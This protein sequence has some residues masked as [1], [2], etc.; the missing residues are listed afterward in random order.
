MRSHH[1]SVRFLIVHTDYP[2]FLDS[3]YGSEPGLADADYATQLDRRYRSRFGV[4]DFYSYNLGELGHQAYDVYANNPVIQA[5]WLIDHGHKDP[6][7]K[8]EIAQA[9][10]GGNEHGTVG[11]LTRLRRGLARRLDET[12]LYR[13]LELQIEHYRPDVLINLKID[14]D[15]GF[16]LRQRANISVLLAQHAASPVDLSSF[17]R[18]YDALLSSFPVTLATARSLGLTAYKLQLAFDERV[19]KEVGDVT[20]QEGS[21]TFI[22]SLQRVHS[23]RLQWLEDLCRQCPTVQV[24]TPDINKVPFDSPI[25]R[26]YRGHAWGIEMYKVLRSSQITLNH[27]GDVAPFANN[28]RLYEATGCGSLLVTDHKDDLGEL[29]EVEKEALS[30]SSV[31]ECAG[32][33][34]HYLEATG[35]RDRIAHAGQSRTLTNHTWRA[36]MEQVVSIAAHHLERTQR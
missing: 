27:H 3:L 35:D 16:F 6:S 36:R 1:R 34:E 22:G 30:Y 20:K 7:T 23:S 11:S 24:W 31:E 8:R 9:L 2:A 18:P 10:R 5:R 19:L 15:P 12:W 28:L 29:F 32:L 4:A 25:R 14:L 21:V 33:I 13:T 17:F 26:S